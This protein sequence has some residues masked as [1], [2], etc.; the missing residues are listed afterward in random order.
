[1]AATLSRFTFFINLSFIS[2]EFVNLL[3]LTKDSGSPNKLT[4][5]NSS[6]CSKCQRKFNNRIIL[7]K[8]DDRDSRE[9]VPRHVGLA[10]VAAPGTLILPVTDAHAIFIC[11]A[12]A[13]A[14][15]HKMSLFSSAL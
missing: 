7:K 5:Y 3:E 14:L 9:C 2:I 4:I 11:P 13:A 8:H 10:Q 12:P 15:G 6:V 1:M